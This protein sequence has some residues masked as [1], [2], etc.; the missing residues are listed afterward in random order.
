MKIEFK[1]P[2][3]ATVLEYCNM[4][5][6]VNRIIAFTIHKYT[7]NSAPEHSMVYASP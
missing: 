3:L 2:K 6:K 4:N 7:D 1:I 5:I